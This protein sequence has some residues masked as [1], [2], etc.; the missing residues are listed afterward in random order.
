VRR[1]H[2]AEGGESRDQSGE[3]TGGTTRH[4]LCPVGGSPGA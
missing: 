2:G 3:Q 1:R 4:S